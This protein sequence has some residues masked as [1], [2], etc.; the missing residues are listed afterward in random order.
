MLNVT[1]QLSGMSVLT[2]HYLSVG[3]IWTGLCSSQQTCSLQVKHLLQS[4]HTIVLLCLCRT[5]PQQ[6]SEKSKECAVCG[7]LN[8]KSL[9]AFCLFKYADQCIV[10]MSKSWTDQ[11]HCSNSLPTHPLLFTSKMAL[12]FRK[13][14]RFGG[15]SIVYIVHTCW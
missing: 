12:T 14:P 2:V 13:R 8:Q 7:T 10:F 3:Q 15:Y 11:K 5:D 4:F 1:F 6:G 9:N